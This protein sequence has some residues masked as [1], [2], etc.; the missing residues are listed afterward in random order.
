MDARV[1]I[2]ARIM[3]DDFPK[4]FSKKLKAKKHR[5]KM[6]NNSKRRNR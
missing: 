6:A 4:G 5:R 2:E 1:F 3:N